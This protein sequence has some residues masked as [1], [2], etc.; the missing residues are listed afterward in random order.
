MLVLLVIVIS[1]LSPAHSSKTKPFKKAWFYDLN[2]GGLFTAR[3][4]KAPPVKAPSGP[5]PNAQPA[6]VKAYVLTYVDEPNESQLFIA[7]LETADPNAGKPEA[8]DTKPSID[9]NALLIEGK[10][11]RTIEDANWVPANSKKGRLIIKKAFRPD[12]NG[13]YPRYWLPE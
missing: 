6:G 13:R 9:K 2:T 8:P 1:L 11:I 4:D 10:L 12:K 5:L 7:F 3:Y